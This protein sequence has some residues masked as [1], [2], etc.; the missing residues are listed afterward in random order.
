MFSLLVL[1]SHGQYDNWELTKPFD[2]TWSKVYSDSAI[3]FSK[4]IEIL[5]S[6]NT[7]TIQSEDD[8]TVYGS[9]YGLRYPIKEYPDKKRKMPPFLINANLSG[10]FIIELLDRGYTVSI[11]NIYSH[12]NQGTRVYVGAGVTKS[13]EQVDPLEDFI[14]KKNRRLKNGFAR[15]IL[16]RLNRLF[17]D[18]FNLKKLENQRDW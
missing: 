3:D 1:N 7:Y 8:E 15:S 6:L 12:N 9:F 18:S 2:T 10:E 14:W 17:I 16:P 11:R 5:G 13:S 4:S